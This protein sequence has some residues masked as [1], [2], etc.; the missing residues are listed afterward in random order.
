[1]TAEISKLE[2]S[3]SERAFFDAVKS[4]A[5]KLGFLINGDEIKG[6]EFS[7]KIE[8]KNENI[9]EW[10][11]GGYRTHQ[12]SLIRNNGNETKIIESK[13]YCSWFTT[14]DDSI[15]YQDGKEQYV[16]LFIEDEFGKK[17]F[18]KL[19]GKK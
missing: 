17:I 12:Y 11:S 2:K 15:D 18:E 5:E 8:I 14:S 4:S 6:K 19:R 10:G 3:V 1:M 13:D 9:H 7:Y 16:K